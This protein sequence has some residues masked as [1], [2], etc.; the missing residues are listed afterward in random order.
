M[1]IS[2]VVATYNNESTLRD[3]LDSIVC[4]NYQD[5]ELIIIDGKSEDSTIDIL[6]EYKKMIYHYESE[7]DN[8]VYDALNKGVKQASGEYVYFIGADDILYSRDTIKNVVDSIE[9]EKYPVVLCGDVWQVDVFSNYQKKQIASDDIMNIYT[10]K[11]MPHHQG[12]F[13]RTNVVKNLLFDVKYKIA[14]DYDMFHKI[15]NEYGRESVKCLDYPIAYFSLGFGTSSQL[16]RG[17]AE[18]VDIMK[19]NKFSSKVIEQY[20]K[21]NNV[22]RY[23]INLKIKKR[24]P[25]S[26]QGIIRRVQGWNKHHC[27]WRKCPWER[28]GLD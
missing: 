5:I 18:Y 7:S 15:I 10:K 2:I 9:S 22:I 17:I 27:E 3:L 6:R 1:K 20:V 4:Q 14:A 26:V 13:I 23:N 11:C 8:G 21:D 28:Q 25:K 12:M 24:I 16:E 19:K